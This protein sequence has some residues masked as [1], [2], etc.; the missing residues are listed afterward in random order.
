MSAAIGPAQ[1][2]PTKRPR[3]F[4]CAVCEFATTTKGMLKRHEADVH[5][6][7]AVFVPCSV[8]GCA[9][10][11]KSNDDVREHLRKCHDIGVTWH[12]C[13]EPRCEFKTK[14][15]NALKKHKQNRHDIDVTWFNCKLC[16]FTCKQ[17]AGVLQHERWMHSDRPVTY[18]ERA[19]R[20]NQAAR[21]AAAS[22]APGSSA[23]H[24]SAPEAARV[25]DVD[26]VDAPKPAASAAAQP[27][28]IVSCV[29]VEGVD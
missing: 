21:A 10:V 11:G 9:Y 25:V 29:F 22:S 3:D 1:L 5:G 20:R 13:T 19:F 28:I 23:M 26:G 27:A 17:R 16:P 18:P 8:Q 12:Y 24:G 7:N 6:R 15:A 14:T 4:V 2:R